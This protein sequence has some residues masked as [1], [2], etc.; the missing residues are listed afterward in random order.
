MN[1]LQQMPAPG[2]RILRCAGDILEF[3]LDVAGAPR[4]GRA[5]VRTNIGRAHILRREIIDHTD[6]AKPYLA[7]DWHDVPM[8]PVAPGRWRV[9]LALAN[10]GFF[11]AKSFFL[12]AGAESPE[13]PEGGNVSVKVAPAFSFCGNS[14][15]TAFTR[16]FREESTAHA[17]AAHAGTIDALGREG[18]AVIPPS[19]TFR[20]IIRRLD[21]IVGDMGFRIIQLLPVHPVPTTYA[22][23]GR[24]GSPFASLDFFNV[25]PAYAEFDGRTTPLDQFRELADAVH[26]REARLFIDL[27]ANHTGWASAFQTSHPEWFRRKADGSFLS[28]GAWGVVWEDLVAL[29]Y[30][31]PALRSAMAEVFLFWCAQGVDG[32]RCDAGYMIP[33]E[34]WQYIIA[35]VREAFPETVFLLEGLGGKI[36]VTDELLTKSNLDW[37]YSELFQEENRDAITAYLGST[38]DRAESIGPLVHFA[39]TH[40]NNR[41]AARGKT[42]SSMRTALSALLSYQGAYGI[43]AGVEW[44]CRDKIDVHG[45]PPLNWGASENQIALLSRLNTLLD[46]HPSF[47]AGATVRL[48]QRGGGNVLA[49]LR[50]RPG[51]EPVLVC[52]N[53]DAQNPQRV[54]WPASLFA[55]V[56]AHDLLADGPVPVARSG[57]VASIPLAPGEVRALVAEAR[58]RQ[59]GFSKNGAEGTRSARPEPQAVA[60]QRLNRLALYVLGLLGDGGVLPPEFA[61]ADAAGDALAADPVAF[62]ARGEDGASREGAMPRCVEWNW[63]RDARRTVMVP[64]GFLVC[65]R[66]P[67]H[68]RA[69]IKDEAGRAIAHANAVRLADGSSATLLQPPEYDGTRRSLT[70]EVVAFEEVPGSRFSVPGSRFSVPGSQFPA[71]RQ[72]VKPSNRQ[73]VVRRVR[74]SLI[75]LPPAKEARFRIAISGDELRAGGQ[76]A[77][78]A[79]R[80][81][82]MS[83]VQSGW[84]SIRSQYDAILA[85]NPNPRVPDNRLVFFTRCLAWVRNRGYSYELDATCTESFTVEKGGRAAVWRFRTPVGMGREVSLVFRLVLSESTNRVD[86]QLIRCRD[87][88]PSALDDGQ[89]VTL[90]LRP[91]VEARDFHCKTL[92]YQGAEQ[93]LPA[94][95]RPCAT[96]FDFTPGGM[97]ACTMRLQGGAFHAEPRWTYALPHPDDASRG[98]GP[99]GDV[100]S[101]GWF[102]VSLRGGEWRALAAGVKGEMA[103]DCSS[104]APVSGEL[105]ATFAASLRRKSEDIRLADWLAA[106]PLAI[107]VAD[108]DSLKTVIAGFPWFLDWGRDTLIVLRGLIAAGKT[109]DAV[110]IIREFGRFEENGT[111]PNIIHGETVGNRDTADAPLWYAVAV[112]DLMDALGAKKVASL[113]CGD[114]TVRDVIRSIVGNYL[115]G[116]P[117]GIRVDHATGLVF[118]PSHFT[119][120][121]TNYPAGTPREGYPVEIQAL[122]IAALALLREKLGVR[123]FSAVEERARASLLRLYVMPEGWLADSLRAKAGQGADEAVAEDALRPNQLLAVTLGAVPPHGDI[124]K[125]ILRATSELLVPG[126]IRS[127]ADRPVNVEQP[128]YGANGLLNDPHNPFWGEYV[129]DEDTRRKPAYHN[130]TAWGWQFPLY[131]EALAMVYGKAAH[132]PAGALLASVAELMGT[133]SLGQLPEILDGA[134]PHIQRG[135]L[136]QAWSVSEVVRVWKLLRL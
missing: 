66:A 133:G 89:P 24:Y 102:E 120:M 36:E 107:Y 79:N 77:V 129:G 114:R 61:N 123:E 90:V 121:D 115:R 134:T 124:S 32:F 101:P 108:R 71:N 132:K 16:Q 1:L 110:A 55:P 96:G 3:T 93:S 27:P 18:Y 127:L 68:F 47:A 128:V 112:R 135:C 40:D 126:S 80:R 14:I 23:M 19:G 43:T 72:T 88:S 69:L 97:P 7:A 41:L 48:V 46:T 76:S 130:G 91:D 42:F 70:L 125:A 136:A 100:F 104:E 83:H 34:T 84:G 11:L 26:A 103:R 6:K 53:L 37:A 30:S 58:P 78:L 98:L 28:P 10:P 94:A 52:V 65:V 117:N 17:E 4:P 54:E 67:V 56:Q 50:E 60:R 57:D 9:R 105:S 13:W 106:D 35:R 87:A 74:A 59:T 5:F 119:W 39:E 31:I 92:A 22:R 51:A 113:K 131:C 12:P 82:A 122:W 25:D 8:D 2:G 15:Y 116:T 21:H 118:S 64:P 95:V 73:T 20:G 49:A 99:S 44:F 45:A 75:L 86:L 63:P 81:G 109:D 62:C 111:L 38:A 85:V 33:A 29:D